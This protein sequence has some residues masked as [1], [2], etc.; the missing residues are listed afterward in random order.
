MLST[1]EITGEKKATHFLSNHRGPQSMPFA[2][3]GPRPSGKCASP[4]LE[5]KVFCNHNNDIL[6]QC[7]YT[8]S[9]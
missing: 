4:K 8:G 9:L 3:L 6:K 5:L 7:K 2:R 1:N